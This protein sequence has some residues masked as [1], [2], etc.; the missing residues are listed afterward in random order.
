[1]KRP[2]RTPENVLVSVDTHY[3]GLVLGS[4]L[5]ARLYPC[6]APGTRL[7]HHWLF[8]L[9]AFFGEHHSTR[10]LMSELEPADRLGPTMRTDGT[11]RPR[12]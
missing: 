8:Y 7:I 10:I 9:G 5:A 11:R 1:M 6:E 4:S 12:Y 2:A 3:C